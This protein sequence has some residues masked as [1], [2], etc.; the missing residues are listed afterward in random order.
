MPSVNGV[1]GSADMIFVPPSSTDPVTVAAALSVLKLKPTSTVVIADSVQNI[2]KNLDALQKVASKITSLTTTDEAQNL[3]VTASQYS[4]HQALLSKWGAGEGNTV[5]V[6]G[7]K[8]ASASSFVA[9]KP[10]YITSITVAD[11]SANIQKNLDGLQTLVSNGDVRQ[12]VQTG[13]AATLKITAAQLAADGDALDA[14]KNHA[15]SLAITDATVAGTLGLEGETALTANAKIKSIA[16]KDTTDA[17]ETNLDALQRVGVRLKSVSQTDAD[18]AITLSGAQYTKDSGVLA[19]I[20]T[21]YHLD[22]I[23]ASAAQSTLLTSNQ[24]V[25]TLS[26]ADTAA[27]L[28]KKW[29][30]LQ[31]LADDLTS[32]EVTDSDHAISITGDQLALSETL[33]S[34]FTDDDDHTYSLA[35]TGVKAGQAMGAAN[36][37]HVT[38][39][40]VSD[41]ADNVAA[42][43]DALASVNELGLLHG[44]GLTGKA[45]TLSMDAARLT[46]DQATVTQG[47]LS[48]ITTGSYSLAVSGVS[49]TAL[50]DLASNAR[51]VSMEIGASSS[52]IRDH[53]DSLYSLGKKVSKIQQSDSGTAIDVTQAT[54]ESRASVLAK[55]DGGYAVNLSAVTANKI[56]A[57]V[58]NAHVAKIAVA[59]TG[60]NLLSHWNALRAAGAT[61]DGVTKTDDGGLALS[62]SQY[63]TGRDDEVLQK[64]TGDL[65]FAVSGAS[66]TQA[67]DIS[68]DDA[69][70]QIDVTDDGS[71]VAGA[72]DDLGDLVTGGKLHSITLN[73]GTTNLALHFSQLDAATDVLALIKGGHY[74]L[75]VDEVEAA[76]AKSLA[77]SNPHVASLKVTGDAESIAGNL[78]DLASIGHKLTSIEQS[79]ADD[80]ALTLTGTQFEQ[81][82]GT[83]AKISG[84]YQAD[85]TA[86]TAA[87]AATFA[88]STWVKSL[89]LEDTGANLAK[90]WDTLTTLGTKLTDIAQS[91][92]TAL[93]LT[94]KAWTSGQSLVE[95]FS[96]DLAVSI[97][98]ASVSD[99]ATLSDDDAVTAIQ[100]NDNAATISDALSDLAAESKLTQIEISDATTPL[101]MTSATFGD[102]TDLLGLVKGGNYQVALSAVDI[103]DV[104]TLGANAHVAS[105][106]VTG[107][108]ADIASSFNAL[109][110]LA[111]VTSIALS[112]EG[113][114]LSLS[115]A[116]IRNGA[117]TLAK[118]STD[119]QIAATGVAMAD[120]EEVGAVEQVATIGISDT[121]ANVAANFDDLLALGGS[122]SNLHLTDATP[123]LTLTQSDWTA[124]ADTLAKIDGSYGVDLSEVE[125]GAAST[126]AGETTV[127][128]ISVSDTAGN[129]ASNWSTLTALYDDGNGKLAG[130]E[131]T[132]DEALT[133]TEQQQ[134]DGAA[135]IAA[136]LPDATIETAG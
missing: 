63:E 122:L 50:D 22:V 9:T 86:V 47:V 7:V 33:L 128:Q 70:E 101:T 23:R 46:G 29:S 91:D 45:F 2:Q 72:L 21:N 100:V 53:L 27:N 3:S 113:G 35:V 25:V 55:I 31:R 84:G 65:T 99:L 49:M 109:A 42:N 81:N 79:D 87:K 119:Y 129:L 34:K 134:T 15:Y 73:P 110:S 135:M 117:D 130:L 98:G 83:L 103:A 88:A 132:D 92:S 20:L 94:V 112:D 19:K 75:A 24:K 32:V 6:T 39:V 97:S 59:D 8:A 58:T 52:D 54:F 118:I 125:A 115:S 48:K 127:H 126:L 104:A 30:T 56:L 121:A 95:K 14:I 5:E 64:F 57:D 106:D 10:D 120:L 36:V 114:A 74:T 51:I 93:P 69:V 124:G 89:A 102:A 68:E 16:V 116:Q 61:L 82:K 17:I 123:R 1:G 4:S 11:T 40:S 37:D 43:L 67:A 78:S 133:L 41:S 26:V 136:L 76:D 96:S 107:A 105:M 13:A 60:K 85:L 131:L 66:V 77:T 44:I 71:A 28:G 62:I 18:E 12:I 111:S 90:A 108:S 80:T 38:A